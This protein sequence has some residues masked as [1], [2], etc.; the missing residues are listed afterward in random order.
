MI[1]GAKKRGRP[2][3]V[4]SNKQKQSATK[5]ETVDDII[6]HL[7]I[8]LKDVPFIRSVD[9][10]NKH[11]GIGDAIG[12][13]AGETKKSETDIFTIAHTDNSN[14]ST[15]SDYSLHTANFF[16]A[17]GKKERKSKTKIIE[18]LRS[19]LKKYKEI[20]GGI[21]DDKRC[22]ITEISN[23]LNSG[24]SGDG[25]DCWWC[26]YSFEGHPF[27]IPGKYENG[28]YHVFGNFCGF[29]CAMS[30]NINM[31]DGDVWTRHSLIKKIWNDANDLDNSNDI[32]PSPPR[33][34]LKKYGGHLTIDEF[35]RNNKI[36]LKE[37]RKFVSP[38]ASMHQYVEEIN[39]HFDEVRSSG[40]GDL[41][42]K[43][44]KPLPVKKNISK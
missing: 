18:D 39:V 7:P 28:K 27:F 10:L 8:Y 6:I 44:S 5:T 24:S 42:I 29:N 38:M 26:S 16:E 14:V 36:F 22:K 13:L 34:T 41:V 1:R 32:R 3:K 25:I 19:E 21:V 11:N 4:D 30:Y 15:D 33:E 43:R 35:R 23:V 31:N 37:Y 2:R 12:D 40:V 20:V 9:C 17:S